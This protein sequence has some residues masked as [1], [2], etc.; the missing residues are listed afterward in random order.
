MVDESEQMEE[1]EMEFI[2]SMTRLDIRPGD[3]IALK[4]NRTLSIESARHLRDSLK[5]IFPDGTKIVILEDGMDIGAIRM[6][7]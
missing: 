2:Q 7:E 4:V 3:I 6:D 5:S 1:H